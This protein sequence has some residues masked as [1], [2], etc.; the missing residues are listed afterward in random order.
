MGQL[1][2]DITRPISNTQQGS[3]CLFQIG[4]G[5]G[6]NLIIKLLKFL[7]SFKIVFNIILC[8]YQHKKWVPKN[9]EINYNVGINT[10]K[11][12]KEQ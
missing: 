7:L 5:S 4:G 6:G 10:G 2:I 11:G 8:L 1:K 3:L 12:A 9:N